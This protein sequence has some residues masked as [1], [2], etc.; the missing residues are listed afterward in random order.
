MVIGVVY[1]SGNKV[2]NI[3]YLMKRAFALRTESILNFN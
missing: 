2:H 1:G 3:V